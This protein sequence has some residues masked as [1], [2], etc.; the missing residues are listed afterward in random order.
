[1]LF[2]K[3]SVI[4][5]KYTLAKQHATSRF[6]LMNIQMLTSSQSKPSTSENTLNTSS[7]RKF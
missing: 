1:M 5:D 4:L 7:R 6:V 3:K 2:A